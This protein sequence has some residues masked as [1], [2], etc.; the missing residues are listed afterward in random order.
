MTLNANVTYDS[1]GKEKSIQ[2]NA[3][4][5]LGFIARFTIND[6]TAELLWVEDE[7][8]DGDHIYGEDMKYVMDY[9]ATLPFVETVELAEYDRESP[10][11]QE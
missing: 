10:G 3:R 5:E 2:I 6:G 4:Q 9:V 8:Q 7:Y 11:E 1:N